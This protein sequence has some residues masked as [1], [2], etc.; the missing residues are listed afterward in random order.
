MQELLGESEFGLITED[1]VQGIYEGIKKMLDD[2][3]LM[4]QYATAAKERGLQFTGKTILKQTEDFF[5]K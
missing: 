4:A 1:S 2:P 5:L 3:S